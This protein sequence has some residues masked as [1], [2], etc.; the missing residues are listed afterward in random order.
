MATATSPGWA[1]TE[2]VGG[3]NGDALEWALA[4]MGTPAQR[5]A[6]RQQPL[7]AGIER[8]LGIAGG[9][10]PDDL[11]SVARRFGQPEA[12]VREAARFYARE[13]LFFPQ[14]DAY[15]VLGV[16][17]DA[18][19]A[20]IKVH[21]RL[22]QHW[23][24]P[25]RLQ[26]E[27]DEIFAARVN[28]AWSQLRSVERRR[29][30]D[31]GRLHDLAKEAEAGGPALGQRAGGEPQ[32]WV[33]QAPVD[34][35][36]RWARRVGFAIVSSVCIGL[37]VLAMRDMQHVPKLWEQ[38]SAEIGPRVAA[39]IDGPNGATSGPVPRSA[40]AVLPGTGET[41]RPLTEVV[42]DP[43]AAAGSMPPAAFDAAMDFPA[44]AEAAPSGAPPV[45]PLLADVANAGI[46]DATIPRAMTD[47]T[48]RWVQP[49]EPVNPQ[50]I[51]ADGPDVP[52]RQL[53][54]SAEVRARTRVPAMPQIGSGPV[55]V[56]AAP[57]APE[58]SPLQMES[59]L[60]T[61]E[62]FVRYMGGVRQASPAIWNSPLI[63]S[64]AGQLRQELNERDAPRFSSPQWRIGSR[65]AVLVVRYRGRDAAEDRDTG[66]LVADLVWREGMWLVVGVGMERLQ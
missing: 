48:R 63:Q 25:D 54:D 55:Q 60:R 6:L 19:P 53:P 58:P 4:L 43:S 41:V 22:L 45:E 35:V 44:A 56:A 10:L 61:G 21:H 30:Y 65:N 32:V 16:E 27:D 20:Q 46:A 26:G 57:D 17:A 7:P 13:V 36:G 39:E 2:S 28:A 3:A 23:L 42:D 66:E 12:H 18:T 1:R 24:H 50:D 51:P 14:A 33:M 29:A 49:A 5:H 59:A 52:E 47:A 9:S 34:G 40:S 64:S 11:A 31:I 15:R 62:A 8:L 37:V 38:P